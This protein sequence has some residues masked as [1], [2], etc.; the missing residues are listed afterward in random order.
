MRS[1]MELKKHALL[2]VEWMLQVLGPLLCCICVQLAMLQYYVVLAIK[3]RTVMSAD[4]R[5]KVGSGGQMTSL[6]CICV[7]GSLAAGIAT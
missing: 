1:R 2:S 5:P 4:M 7:H 3:S 6:S